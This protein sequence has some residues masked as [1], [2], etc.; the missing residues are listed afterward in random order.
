MR[1][2]ARA[3]LIVVSILNGLAGLICGVLLMVV[4]DGRLLQMG[5]LLPVVKTLPLANIFFRDFFWIGLAML[6]ALGVPN[7]IAALM[8]VQ[9]SEEQYVATLVAGVLLVLWCGFELIYLSNVPAVGYFAVGVISVL[10]SV[11][12][13]RPADGPGA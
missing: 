9:R 6:L 2:M 13:L 1:R 12:L 7:L 11:L 5:S 8:L 4:P 3:F 10:L